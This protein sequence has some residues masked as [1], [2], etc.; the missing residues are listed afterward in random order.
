MQQDAIN[1][2]PFDL[3]GRVALVTGSTRGLGLATARC[4][5]A[6]CALALGRGTRFWEIRQL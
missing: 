4:L 3:T 6:A 1:P 2:N 5:A